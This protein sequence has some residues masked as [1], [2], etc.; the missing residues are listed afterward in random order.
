M[1]RTRRRR[2]LPASRPKSPKVDDARAVA[3]SHGGR[4]GATIT[5]N[6]WR[7]SMLIALLGVDL[8]ALG[9]FLGSQTSSVRH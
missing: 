2:L 9:P 5:H 8:A 6:A 3:I 7:S 4:R 1:N